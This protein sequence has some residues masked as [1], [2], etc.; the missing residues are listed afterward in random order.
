MKRL[1][2][3][4]IGLALSG[5]ALAAPSSYVE[6]GYITGGE[7]GENGSGEENGFEF[8]G[9]YA[10]SKMWYA[11]GIIGSYERDRSNTENDYF[12]INGGA[13][14]G[15]TERTD[16]ITE[17]GLW[18]GEQKTSGTKTEPTALEL[19]VGVNT[20]VVDK[21][22]LFGHISLIGGDLD[23][24]SNSDLTNFVWSIGGAYNFTPN[25]SLN[26]KIVEGSNGVNGQSDVVRLGGR[27]TFGSR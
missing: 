19:K 2:I 25:F 17:V 20:L 5:A 21:L 8:A 14:F 18:F 11:G 12:N 1:S 23:T 15:M 9:S 26:L 22:A 24:P 6:L 3:A 27:W 10:F 7:N 16:L 13:T 4:L